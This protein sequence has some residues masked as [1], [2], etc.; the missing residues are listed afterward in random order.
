[1][2]KSILI[3]VALLLITCSTTEVEEGTIEDT[4]SDTESTITTQSSNNNDTADST[5]TSVVEK[6]NFD[7][8]SDIMFSSPILYPS[9][10]NL[11]QD[12]MRIECFAYEPPYSKASSFSF[13]NLLL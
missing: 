11:F 12:H 8:D 9:D 10:L 3:I 4:I 1:M 5:T 7:N 13:S 2:K 6:Y